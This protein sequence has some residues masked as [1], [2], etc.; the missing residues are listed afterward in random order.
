MIKALVSGFAF[1]GTDDTGNGH[2]L[3]NKN[4]KLWMVHP[5][6][7]IWSKKDRGEVGFRNR[8]QIKHIVKLHDEQ[9]NPFNNQNAK[10]LKL[11][12][13][14]VGYDVANMKIQQERTDKIVDGLKSL[15]QSID[16][17][18]VQQV[19]VDSF[20]N[21]VEVVYKNGVKDTYTYKSK[22]WL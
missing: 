18:P 10:F 17:K 7:Q 20:G 13:N 19:N 21:L 6:E 5:Q 14:K 15:K 4:G 2:G 12:G 9:I 11:Q 1:D 3:D 8:D 22:K 16:N